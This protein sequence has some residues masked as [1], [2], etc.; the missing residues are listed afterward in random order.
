MFRPADYGAVKVP[1]QVAQAQDAILQAWTADPRA[2]AA[3]EHIGVPALVA[4]ARDDAILA[5]RNSEALLRALPGSASLE[6]DDA[7]HAMMY[8]YPR[9]LARRLGEFADTGR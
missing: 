4:Y 3:L 7:G 2:F 1:A 8:Q 5:P 9:A 6:V